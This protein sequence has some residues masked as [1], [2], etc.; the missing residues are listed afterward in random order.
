MLDSCV[1]ILDKDVVNLSLKCYSQDMENLIYNVME[2]IWSTMIVYE[3]NFF[4]QFWN[5]IKTSCI[6]S[7]QLWL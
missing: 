2:E 1:Q 5:S 7:H 6:V 4:F 3:E